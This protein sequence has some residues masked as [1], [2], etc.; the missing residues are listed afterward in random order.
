MNSAAAVMGAGG[1]MAAPFPGAAGPGYH[2]AAAPDP[3]MG[4]NPALLTVVAAQMGNGG[5]WRAGLL[6]WR[7]LPGLCARVGAQEWLA[8]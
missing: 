1:Y 6:L 5:G 7:C 2:M 3:N 8:G 4:I